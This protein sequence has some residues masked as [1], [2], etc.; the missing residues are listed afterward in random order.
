MNADSEINANSRAPHGEWIATMTI[1]P[2]RPN[3]VP[4]RPT[5]P[6]HRAGLR[7]V[8]M[9]AAMAIVSALIVGAMGNAMARAGERRLPIAGA[10][11]M[12]R[13]AQAVQAFRNGQVADAYGRFA[14]L[15]DGG[16]G[17]SALLALALVR[18]GP[19]LYGS[20]WSV[21]EGQLR[22][23]SRIAFDDLQ[24]RGAQIAEHDRGE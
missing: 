3:R 1:E 16:D 6:S 13:Q 17:G 14:A 24:Q 7:P 22:R 23:W 19:A 18:H 8:L 4:R 2:A 20:Q 9:I 5:G 10:E 11:Q 15:A 21:T 12:R